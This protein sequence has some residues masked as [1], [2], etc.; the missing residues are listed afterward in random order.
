MSTA[1]WNQ[2]SRSE[3]LSMQG[4]ELDEEHDDQ[5]IDRDEKDTEEQEKDCCSGCMKCLG[6]SWGDFI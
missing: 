2:W 4:V 6:L 5:D 3:L 1:Y